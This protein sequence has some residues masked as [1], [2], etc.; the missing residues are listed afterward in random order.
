MDGDCPVSAR[1]VH[2][3]EPQGISLQVWQEL[4][5]KPLGGVGCAAPQTG[6]SPTPGGTY[7]TSLSVSFRMLTRLLRVF[8]GSWGGG[9]A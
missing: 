4:L 6:L 3:P 5:P 9:A 8:T 2:I 1:A 7:F